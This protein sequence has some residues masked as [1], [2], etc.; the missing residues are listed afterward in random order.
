MRTFLCGVLV[1]LLLGALP[2][3]ADERIENH[4]PT[5]RLVDLKT[6]Y[7]GLSPQRDVTRIQETDL[8]K[9]AKRAGVDLRKARHPLLVATY[10]KKRLFYVFYKAAE[11]A[12]GDRPYVIQRIKKTERTWKDGA[13]EPDVRTTWQVEVFKTLE[14]RRLPDE[15]SGCSAAMESSRCWAWVRRRFRSLCG[16]AEA[17]DRLRRVTPCR[18]AARCC[19]ATFFQVVAFQWASAHRGD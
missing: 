2:V 12:F 6:G 8:F 17:P 14:D 9:T 5:L 13:E 3:G 19:K 4:A 16:G 15:M 11:G 1:A 18:V 7:R 10:E